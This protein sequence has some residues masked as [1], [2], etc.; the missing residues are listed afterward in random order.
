MMSV[1]G[2]KIMWSVDR[3]IRAFLQDEMIADNSIPWVPFIAMQ[4]EGDQVSW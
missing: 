2:D 3:E 4:H 1:Y